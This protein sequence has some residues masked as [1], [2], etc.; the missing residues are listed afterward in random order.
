MCNPM[1]LAA[2]ASPAYSEFLPVVGI[3]LPCRGTTGAISRTVP[4]LGQLLKSL[5]PSSARNETR[6][7]RP[8]GETAGQ[9]VSLGFNMPS[10]ADSALHG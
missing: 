1:G 2:R 4:Q 5:L 7:V 8:K 10:A 6:T 3:W 9:V